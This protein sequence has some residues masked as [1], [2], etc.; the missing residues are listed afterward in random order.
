MIPLWKLRDK[1]N[2]VVISLIPL[3]L[4]A[5]AIFYYATSIEPFQISTS[6]HRFNLTNSAGSIKVVI[7]SDLHAKDAMSMDFLGKVVKEINSCEPDII[8]ILGDFIDYHEHEIK[9]LE[10]LGALNA[11][12]GIYAVLGNHD[13]GF[14]WSNKG[15]ADKV[16]KKLEDLNIIVLRNENRLIDINGTR[17]YL[18]GSDSLWAGEADLDKA[19]EGIEENIPEIL[20]C[21][22]PDIVLINKSDR[23]DLIL[24]GHT[25]GGQVNLPLIGPLYVNTKMGGAYT[26]GFYEINDRNIYITRGIGGSIRFR[27]NSIPEIVVMEFT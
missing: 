12:Y 17:F 8:L 19:I 22:N 21:H 4:I 6:H 27:L 9:F 1:T 10:P 18:V 13:Y 3:L 25:H 14:G 24:S 2:P 7:F 20:L 11:S 26:N 23:F 16:E 15:L 5:A